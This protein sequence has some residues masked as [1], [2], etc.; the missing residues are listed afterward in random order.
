M[1]YDSGLAEEDFDRLRI[2]AAL[3]GRVYLFR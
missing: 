3:E 1:D 2:R